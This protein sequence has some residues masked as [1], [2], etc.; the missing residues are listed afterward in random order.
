MS[1]DI[2]LTEAEKQK[3]LQLRERN[4]RC[5]LWWLTPAGRADIRICWPK[6]EGYKQGEIV[7][8]LLDALEVAE[9]KLRV[10]TDA[11]KALL[12]VDK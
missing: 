4:K 6:D 1:D 8:V 2:Q 3:I 5:G 11:Y 10:L 12:E 9:Q 7:P